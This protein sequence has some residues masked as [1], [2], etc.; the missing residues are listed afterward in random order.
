VC[1]DV[2]GSGGG[3]GLSG[4]GGGGC[5]GLL[6]SYLLISFPWPVLPCSLP[7]SFSSFLLSP[8]LILLSFLP[9]LSCP[10]TPCLFPSFP[11]SPVSFPISISSSSSFIYS[12]R[13]IMNYM[14]A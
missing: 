11:S 9:F 1:S 8:F 6:D 7:F 3:G 5:G 4:G 10:L 14:Q 2:G 13:H 12:H